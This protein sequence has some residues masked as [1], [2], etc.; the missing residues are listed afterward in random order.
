M[1]WYCGEGVAV[2]VGKGV[3]GIAVGTGEWALL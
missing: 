1:R 3:A 2:T